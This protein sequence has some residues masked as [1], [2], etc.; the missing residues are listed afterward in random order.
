VPGRSGDLIYQVI[1]GN[2]GMIYTG[3]VKSAALAQYK[4]Y[5]YL[6]KKEI[7]RVSRESVTLMEDDE[8]I[9]EHIGEIEDGE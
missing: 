9:R 6:S 3:I 8:I 4:D 5:V 1:V 2:V 7:G